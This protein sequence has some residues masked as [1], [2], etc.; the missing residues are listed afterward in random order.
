[1]HRQQ[2]AKDLQRRAVPINPDM[3]APPVIQRG[4]DPA[5]SPLYHWRRGLVG[6]VQSWAC[7]SQA[8]V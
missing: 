8:N 4:M 5:K 6:A 1:M 7:G 3:E 2:L